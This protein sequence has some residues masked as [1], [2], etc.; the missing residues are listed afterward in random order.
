MD[1]TFLKLPAVLQL[2]CK[3][4]SAHYCDIQKGL[5]TKP[6][7]LGA[8]SVAWPANELKVINAAIIAGQ[9]EAEIMKLVNELEKSRKLGK[10]GANNE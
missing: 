3:S 9:N 7:K 5:F 6:V 8:R 2:R 1:L 4:R 10:W